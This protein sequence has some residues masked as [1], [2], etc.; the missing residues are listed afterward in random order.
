M[1]AKQNLPGKLGSAILVH[2]GLKDLLAMS[3]H[4]SGF[5]R[6]NAVRR[7]AMLGKPIAIPYLIVRVNDWVPQ[8]RAAALDALSRLLGTGNGEAFVDSL[9]AIMHLQTCMRDNHAE[10]VRAV[11]DFLL[12]EEN[13]HHLVAGMHS[14]DAQVARLATRL[15]VERKRMSATV[16][17][18]AGLSHKD[19]VVRS[20]VVNLLAGLEEPAFTAAV[21]M[22]LRDPYMPVR[23]EAFQ[24]LLARDVVAG[25][26][27]AR[28]MLFDRS[29][30][31]R[32]IAVRRLLDAGEP[33]EQIYAG[34]LVDGAGRVTVV[35][36][37]LWSW[38]FMNS[39]AHSK[40]ARQLLCAPFPAVR[41]SALQTVTKLLGN[42]ARP[43]LE[44][45]LADASP[46]VCKEAARLLIKTAGRPSAARLVSIARE[47]GLRHVAI[48]CC[49]VARQASK[50]DWLR[51][52]LSAYGAVDSIVSW[53]TLY[54]E[55]DAWDRKFN[56]SSAQPDRDSMQEIV[57]ALRVCAVKLPED[58]LRLLKFTLRA[59][60]G[61]L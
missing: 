15:L 27:V 41:R 58:Q 46:A 5:K 18:T 55:I 24:Q 47:S 60:G 20:T 44:A 49:R 17:I 6:E 53:E 7:L 3:S 32:E 23:R 51:F 61:L 38:A 28:D 26:R 34:A 48:A 14:R 25:L 50:W 37:V 45:A 4:A 22:A 29:P 2:P 9:P 56:C 59:Y 11:Q 40:Q 43:H 19:I 39:R 54:T 57:S 33:V 35:T 52:I 1:S 36:C 16:L 13:V 31:I 12:R 42:D 10:L 30:S 8:V 21:A